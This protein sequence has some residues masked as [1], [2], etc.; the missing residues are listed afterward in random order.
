MDAISS[1]YGWVDS[2]ILDLY[3]CRVCQIKD[4][5]YLRQHSEMKNRHH[6]SEWATKT[7]SAFVIASSGIVPK[8]KQQLQ[9]MLESISLSDTNSDRSLLPDNGERSLEDIIENGSVAEA[10]ERNGGRSLTELF[11]PGV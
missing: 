1:Q 11:N 5:I 3:L 2:E 8:G 9:K 6:E 10:L 4:S 7:V